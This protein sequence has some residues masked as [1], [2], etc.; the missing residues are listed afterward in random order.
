MGIPQGSVSNPQRHLLF[1]SPQKIKANPFRPTLHFLFMTMSLTGW[2]KMKRNYFYFKKIWK[3][4]K[5]N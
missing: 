5:E 4:V 1:L 2:R 3:I